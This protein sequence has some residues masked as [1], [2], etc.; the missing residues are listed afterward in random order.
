MR[1]NKTS[2]LIILIITVLIVVLFYA[3]YKAYGFYRYAKAE[4]K[5]YAY[6]V[7][8]KSIPNST[9]NRGEWMG[10]LIDDDITY[11]DGAHN[12]VPHD[13]DRDGK[14]ELIANSYRSDA[15]ILYKYSGNPLNHLNWKRYVIDSQVGGG[16]PTKPVKRFIKLM[17]IENLFN[18][19]VS[20]AHY[21]AIADLNNDSRDDLIVA[22]DQKKYDIVWYEA[23]QNIT[24]ISAWRKHLIYRNDSHLTYHV[25]TGDIDSDG[26]IDIVGAG[27]R[28]KVLFWIRNE[29]TDE[30]WRSFCI[31]KGLIYFNVRV[32][33][34]DNNGRNEII[35]TAINNGVYLYSYS[36]DPTDPSDWSSYKIC[37]LPRGCTVFEIG[38]MDNNGYLDII[39]RSR[40]ATPT[41]RLWLL[42]NPSPDN[43]RKEWAKYL[44]GDDIDA[45]E[46]AIG[47]INRDGYLDVVVADAGDYSTE[48]SRNSVIWFQNKGATFYNNWEKNIIDKSDEYLKWCHSVEVGD[49]DGDGI[50]DVAVAAANSNVFLYYRNEI[51]PRK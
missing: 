26:D 16:N 12:I 36:G 40:T 42:Q 50:P 33:D 14:M 37:S 17:L 47:D 5:R 21:T 7:P 43:V 23:P 20:G 11:T 2:V 3:G 22:C 28:D 9:F 4:K 10:V 34:L 45:R 1:N 18:G 32:A 41:S 15:L 27:K 19:F 31:D 8:C 29:G 51:V 39:V 25:E 30:N 35:A 46:I 44:I 13:L 49:I 6:K 38:D 48:R 24:D